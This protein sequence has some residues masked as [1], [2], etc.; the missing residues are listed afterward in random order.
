MQRYN[1]LRNNSDTIK[2]EIK[3]EE[4]IEKRRIFVVCM[5]IQSCVVLTLLKRQKVL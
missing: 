3:K 1:Q 2:K 5:K 4:V